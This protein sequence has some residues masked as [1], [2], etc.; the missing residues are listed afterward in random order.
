[1]KYIFTGIGAF[2]LLYFFDFYTL[3]DEGMKKKVFGVAGL[4]LLIYSAI[5]VAAVSEKASF[6][7]IQRIIAG[8]FC[9]LA[10]FL[11]IYSLFLELPFVKTY[12]TDQHNNVLVDTGTYAL[13]RHPGVLWFGLLFFFFFFATGA[14]LLIPAGII[15]TSIDAVHVY[16]QEKLF[17]HKMFPE[18][19]NYVKNTP[20]LFPT[21]KSLKRCIT[22]LL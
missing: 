3:K 9:A 22:T 13:C 19:G 21:V 5:M 18:Y 11:L 4:G 6:P 10:A 7:V 1:M 14:V 12:G 16:L 20:M 2:V 8:V 17:F 15:W